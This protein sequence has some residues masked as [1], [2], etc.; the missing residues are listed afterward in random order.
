MALKLPKVLSR[1]V[2]KMLNAPNVNAH[3]AKEIAPCS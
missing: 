1:K 2:D 3:R